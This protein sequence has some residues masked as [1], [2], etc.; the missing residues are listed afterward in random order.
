[1]LPNYYYEQ[2]AQMRQQELEREARQ[3]RLAASIK[4]QS[5]PARGL[6]NP[7]EGL[8]VRLGLSMKPKAQFQPRIKPVTGNL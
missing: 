4:S 6:M 3:I 2:Y 1:M 5:N 7:V 8:L